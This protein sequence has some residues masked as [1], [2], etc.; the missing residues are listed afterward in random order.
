MRDTSRAYVAGEPA[1]DLDSLSQAVARARAGT[2]EVA[3]V[4]KASTFRPGAPAFTTLI[5]S[6]GRAGA[7]EKACELYDAMK[8]RGVAANTI[9]CSA[10]IN[11]CGKS[12]QWEKALEIF[13]E[14]ERDGVEANI[15]TYSALISACAKGKQLDKALEMFEACRAAGVEPDAI[16]YGAV[17]S[18][19]EKGRRVDKAL[20]IFSEM[21]KGPASS[22][23]LPERG[24]KNHSGSGVECNVITYN[25]LLSA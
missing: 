1:K 8:A 10:L 7:W 14:M 17:I 15:F 22:S 18:A 20:E 12:R 3:R 6:C 19:C 25:A 23:H 11:A 21:K 24:R 4:L 16:T 5:K 13:H 2:D 9:T